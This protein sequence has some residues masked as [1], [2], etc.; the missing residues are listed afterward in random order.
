[1]CIGRTIIQRA[2]FHLKLLSG[3]SASTEEAFSKEEG[4][5]WGHGVAQCIAGGIIKIC[6]DLPRIFPIVIIACLFVGFR[7]RSFG[8]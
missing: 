8:S 4:V 7:E 6:Q 3:S 2:S 1:M 5:F